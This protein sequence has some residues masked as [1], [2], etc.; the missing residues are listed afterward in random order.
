MRTFGYQTAATV[1]EAIQL[2]AQDGTVKALAGGT[3]LITL[4]KAGVTSPPQLI[5]IKQLGEIPQGV[6]FSES[7]AT[8]GARTTLAD[9]ELNEQIQSYLPLLAQA[10]GLA[11]TPQLRNMA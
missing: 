2:L 1:D 9:I 3:D 8:I 4:M 11:A 6:E 10:A 7:G 5:D